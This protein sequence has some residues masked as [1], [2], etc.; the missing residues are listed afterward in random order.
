VT[1]TTGVFMGLLLCVQV[2]V[3]HSL[4]VVLLA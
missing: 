1:K 2:R 3:G 4:M